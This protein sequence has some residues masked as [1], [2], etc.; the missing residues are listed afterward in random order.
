MITCSYCYAIA[1]NTQI[2]FCTQIHT[3]IIKIFL[4]CLHVQLFLEEN[5][6]DIFYIPKL[7]KEC[8][9]SKIFYVLLSVLDKKKITLWRTKTTTRVRSCGSG[10]EQNKQASKQMATKSWDTSGP[11]EAS[12]CIRLEETDPAVG[13]GLRKRL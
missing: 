12:S 7:N 3:S 4:G 9:Q 2:T 6:Q 11:S 1:Q 10:D 8:L 5:S 13:N